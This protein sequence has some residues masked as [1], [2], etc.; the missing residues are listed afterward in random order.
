MP[1][2]KRA[3]PVVIRAL[4]TEV[5]RIEHQLRVIFR[6]LEARHPGGMRALGLMLSLLVSGPQTVSQL[7]RS[8]HV[9]RQWMQRAIGELAALKLVTFVRNPR[10]KRAKLVQVTPLGAERARKIEESSIPILQEVIPDEVSPDSV[11]L[12]L[13]VLMRINSRLDGLVG[14]KHKRSPNGH[15]G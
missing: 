2:K 3:D 12:A 6:P 5:V 8:R 13:F 10:H 4:L 14:R 9:S 7:A 15:D 1:L 11:Q